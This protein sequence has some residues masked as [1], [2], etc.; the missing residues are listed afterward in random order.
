MIIMEFKVLL[1][2][3]CQEPIQEMLFHTCILHLKEMAYLPNGGTWVTSD[4]ELSNGNIGTYGPKAYYLQQTSF[5]KG[6]REEIQIQTTVI[7]FSI[8]VFTKSFLPIPNG[9]E[10][11]GNDRRRIKASF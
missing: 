11:P 2:K 7:C 8:S 1:H 4:A 10:T 3:Q 9:I 5:E 6:F